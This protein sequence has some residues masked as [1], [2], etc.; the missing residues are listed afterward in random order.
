M[1]KRASLLLLLTVASAACGGG[2]PTSPDGG[3]GASPTPPPGSPVSGYLFYDENGNG[4]A[5]PNETVRFPSVGVAIGG[6]SATTAAGGRFSITSVPNGAQT[7]QARTE[8]LPAYFTATTI[9]VTVPATGDVAVPVRLLL[10]SRNQPN[11]YL[12]FGDSIT[13]GEGSSDD[14]GYL[15]WLNAQLR[16]FWGKASMENDGAPGTRSNAGRS[17]LPGSL[18]T[19]RPAYALILYGTNDWNEPECRDAPPCYTIDSLRS[20]IEDTK[21]AGAWPI[22]ATIPPVNPQYTDHEP[23][24]RNAWVKS[25][26]DLVRSMA[27][28]EKAPVADVYADFMKQSSLP[29]LYS[30]FLHPNDAGYQIVAQAFFRAITQPLAGSAAEVEDAAPVLFVPP[31]HH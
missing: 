20:M 21:S 22:V 3:G 25:M 31:R 14:Q 5:D 16:S 1:S 13:A 15:S 27:A 7:G 8:T 6:Q 18:A 30:D 26:N 29:P 17:R 28:S 12:A 19:Y 23:T 24:E 2:G 11:V 4:I 10:G 9:N